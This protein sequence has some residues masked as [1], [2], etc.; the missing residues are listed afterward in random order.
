MLETALPV[1]LTIVLVASPL[2]VQNSVYTLFLTT[3]LIWAI[4]ALFFDVAF[5]G[6]GMMSFGH[7]AFFGIGAYT[8]GIVGQLTTWPFAVLLLCAVGV[9]LLHGLIVAAIG[10]RSGGVYFGLFTLGM[11]EL[12]NIMVATRLRPLTGG[13]DGL[14]GL[15]QPDLAWTALPFDVAFYVMTA[16]CFV[17]VMI[18]LRQ[19]KKS[20]F[21]RVLAGV[22]LNDLRTAQLGFNVYRFR[23]AAFTISAG[24]SAL[25]GALL[26]SKMLYVSPEL[27]HWGVSG[28]ILMI[29]VIGGA[30]TLAGPVV[31][32]LVVEALRHYFSEMTIYWRGL[33]GL[34]FILVTLYMP[35]G[36]VGQI[37]AWRLR[38]RREGEA[39]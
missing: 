36:I 9:G 24:G 37:N 5:G 38:R 25:A 7:A 12:L 6:T 32:V 39:Q 23:V 3:A 4:F 19:L 26:G 1:V 28:D 18:A 14:S 33:I 2:L 8:L 15:R 10:A 35:H 29:S 13:A 17:A 22:R 20:A 31:G 34:V 16:L 27:L 21:G 30:G 11:A